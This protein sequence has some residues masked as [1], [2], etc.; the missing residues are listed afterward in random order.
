MATPP[1]LPLS[2]QL[3]EKWKT[4]LELPRSQAGFLL[5]IGGEG[6]AEQTGSEEG[7]WAIFGAIA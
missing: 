5:R 6:G 7:L 3:C 2:A 4:C 1:V